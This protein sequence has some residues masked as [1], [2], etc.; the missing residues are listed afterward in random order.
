MTTS[1]LESM[2][3]TGDLKCKLMVLAIDFVLLIFI[4]IAWIF[5]LYDCLNLAFLC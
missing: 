5:R 2:I 4:S 3:E 1:Y